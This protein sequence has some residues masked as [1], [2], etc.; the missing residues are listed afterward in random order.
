VKNAKNPAIQKKGYF[1]KKIRMKHFL[2]RYKSQIL[3]VFI[4]VIWIAL[5]N[6]LFSISSQHYIYPD[7][8]SYRE[9]GFL[10]YKNFTAHYYRPM[11]MA[12]IFGLP[13]LFGGNDAAVYEF[14]TVINLLSWLGSALLLFSFLKKILPYNKAF[15]FTLVFYTLL[16]SAFTI[17]HLLSESIYIFLILFSFYWIDRYYRTALFRYL[18][19]SLS[20][21]IF[22]ILIKPG[23]KLLAIVFV[24]FFCRIL[25]KNLF[26]R[27]T[28]LIYLSLG[29]VLFQCIKMK[30][31]YG[32]FTIS[33]IDGVT[34]YNYLGSRAVC[35]KA[36]AEFKQGDNERANYI[37]SRPYPETKTIAAKD[38]SDQLKN[39]T[40][41]LLKAYFID[42]LHN[43]KSP[44]DCIERCRNLHGKDYFEP[45]KKA[46]VILSKYQ[47]RIITI[48]GLILALYYFFRS[49]KNPDIYTLISFYILYTVAISGVSSQQ[50]DRFHIVFFPFVII[51]AG[52]WYAQKYQNHTLPNQ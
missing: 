45:L 33:Y 4:G 52:K 40:V 17:F 46:M 51:L 3:L 41:N 35:L 30:E 2:L 18:A 25:I 39:N 22:M 20:I 26:R 42:I 11:G 8:D 9:A 7:S 50:G 34:Y 5:L 49:Y 27:S 12:A 31:Q 38:F 14:S 16:G 36:G 28:L 29:L 13:Y 10:L 47:N 21:L 24:V 44:S 32:N 19:F 15:I 1:Y 23:A 48:F 6:T 37:F 43:T